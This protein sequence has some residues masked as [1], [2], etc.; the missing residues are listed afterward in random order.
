VTPQPQQD[1]SVSLSEAPASIGVERGIFARE[2]GRAAVIAAMAFLTLVDLFATQAILPSLAAHYGT[3]PAQTGLAVNATTLGMAIASLGIALFATRI[4]RRS[5][6]AWSLCALAVPTALLAFAP[7]LPVFAALRVAQGLCMAWAF[8]LT[9]AYLGEHASARDA[10]GAFAAYITGNVAS[11]LF[12]RLCAAFFVDHYGLAGNF[13]AFA[14]LNLGGAALAAATL[15]R[16]APMTRAEAT[17]DHPL[18][19]WGRHLATP[20]LPAAF[21]VG[22]CILFAFVGTF[23][24]VNFVLALPPI[25]LGMMQIGLVYLVFAPSIATTALAGRL[26]ASLGPRIAA[27]SALG[28]AAG[29]AAALLIPSVG[30]VLA[31][32]ALV[33]VGTFLAQA[34]TTGF[35]GSVARS[36]RGAASGLYLG[37]YFAGGLAGSA[38][39]GALFDTLGW[40]MCVAGII[41]ALATAAM[42]T[43]GLVIGE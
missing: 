11:N 43:R 36:D 37:A 35:V 3:T 25:G 32:L 7:N 16:A 40:A 19:V 41:A 20:G 23:T 4:D 14:A 28:L 30:W 24:Y 2:S 29:G 5:G 6:V 8:A 38:V 27:W 18:V 39:L 34:V 31:G 42:L 26:A 33:G 13:F 15:E 10:A 9:L 1:G 12:G 21:G 17:G 22:F